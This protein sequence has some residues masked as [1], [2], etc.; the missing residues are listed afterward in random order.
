LGYSFVDYSLIWLPFSDN[1]SA[2]VAE[3]WRR[4][5]FSLEGGE[6]PRGRG[7]EGAE[8]GWDAAPWKIFDDSIL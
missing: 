2:T 5:D 3:L 4:Q 8:R 7:T 1:I 6:A